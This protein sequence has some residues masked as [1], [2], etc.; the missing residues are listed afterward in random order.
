MMVVGG[1]AGDDAVSAA[2]SVGI[3]WRVKLFSSK[4]AAEYI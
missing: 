1:N 3:G 2:K 4:A